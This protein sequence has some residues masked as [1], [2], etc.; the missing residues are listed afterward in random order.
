MGSD[1]S[2]IHSNRLIQC[3]NVV[4]ISCHNLILLL[5]NFSQ[6]HDEI[7]RRQILYSNHHLAS[8]KLLITL[9]RAFLFGN[10]NLFRV[11]ITGSEKGTQ[12]SLNI[13]L[14]LVCVIVV[15]WYV[16]RCDRRTTLMILGVSFC[17]FLVFCFLLNLLVPSF[18][19]K[20][21]HRQHRAVL[22]RYLVS[23]HTWYTL[24]Q[25][26]YGQAWLGLVLGR[27]RRVLA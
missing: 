8:S 26:G 15:L 17:Q 24:V 19:I 12:T 14:C 23:Y 3:Y 1:D 27:V 6:K 7:M 11:K 18:F 9:R 5:A 21:R 2:Y 13:A 16:A 22:L 25:Q 10:E 20:D 4:K